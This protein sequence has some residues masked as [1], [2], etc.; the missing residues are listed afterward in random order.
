MGECLYCG[1]PNLV[2]DE[3]QGDPCFHNTECEFCGWVKT[4]IEQI[5]TQE[6]VEEAIAVL[7]LP[8]FKIVDAQG[9]AVCDWDFESEEAAQVF[10]PVFGGVGTR[11]WTMR[12]TGDAPLPYWL[13][14]P[15][16]A[17]QMPGPEHEMLVTFGHCGCVEEDDARNT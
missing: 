4:V 3:Q 12:E 9:T 15:V 14:C 5:P 13:E 11:E 16:C 6:Q 17:R 10:V 8:W 1:N 7:C 2:E